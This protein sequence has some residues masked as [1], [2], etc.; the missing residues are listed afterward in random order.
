MRAEVRSSFEWKSLTSSARA[1]P[2]PSGHGNPK[3][4]TPTCA[5]AR[6]RGRVVRQVCA[7]NVLEDD[8]AEAPHAEPVEVD[9]TD[10]V[11]R[12]G[13]KTLAQRTRPLLAARERVADREVGA[14][15][16]TEEARALIDQAVPLEVHELAE[17]RDRAEAA[18]AECDRRERAA[19]AARAVVAER[20]QRVPLEPARGRRFGE[21]VAHVAPEPLLLQE[22]R[23]QL[24]RIEPSRQRRGPR[25]RPVPPRSRAPSAPRAVAREVA[26]PLQYTQPEGYA[27][28]GRRDETVMLRLIDVPP[29]TKAA[30]S[31]AAAT[32]T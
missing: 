27:Q 28:R 20:E 12:R 1:S 21:L 25:R 18:A 14:E 29:T 16:A 7:K 4:V 17:V 6:A 24:A 8:A 30:P 23:L 15:A 26:P 32:E 5:R 9:V 19:P 22:Q 13:D 31:V 11:E 2:R 3:R 10:E